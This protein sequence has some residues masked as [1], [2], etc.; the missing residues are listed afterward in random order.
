MVEFGSYDVLGI[1]YYQRILPIAIYTTV[2]SDQSRQFISVSFVYIRLIIKY[3]YNLFE[4]FLCNL[5]QFWIWIVLFFY[6]R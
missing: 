1:I 2:P 3:I 5:F 6:M 4:F